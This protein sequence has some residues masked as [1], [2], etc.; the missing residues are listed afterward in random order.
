MTLTKTERKTIVVKYIGLSGV[1]E[2]SQASW[3]EVGSKAPFKRWSKRNNYTVGIEDL[4]DA[5]LDYLAADPV[6]IVVSVLL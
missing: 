3:N 5:A 1:R 4:D 6:F 2:I